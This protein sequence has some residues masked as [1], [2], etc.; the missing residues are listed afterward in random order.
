MPNRFKIYVAFEVEGIQVGK[1]K[2]QD[3]KK[4][5]DKEMHAD[6]TFVRYNNY[7]CYSVVENKFLQ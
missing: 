6:R 3:R 4:P 7:K 2:M 1:E 5:K